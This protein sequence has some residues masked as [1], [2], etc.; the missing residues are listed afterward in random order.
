MRRLDSTVALRLALGLLA[1]GLLGQ[2]PKPSLGQADALCGR[3]RFLTLALLGR[4]CT[5]SKYAAI[6][7]I[8]RKIPGYGSTRATVGT[9]I[10]HTS[11]PLLVQD[12]PWEP[13]IDNGYPNVLRTPTGEW[14]LF[15]GTCQHS[16][17]TQILLFANSTDGL[18]WN[19]PK[20][21]LFDIGTIR[22]DLKAIGKANNVLLEGGG[23]GVT[24]DESAPPSHRYVAFGPGCYQAPNGGSCML[25]LLQGAAARARYY[26][27][28]D[29]AFSADGLTYSDARAIQWPAPQ[30]YDCHNN[31]WR[32]DT[33]GGGYEWLATTRDGFGQSP[34]RTIG[35]AR[36]MGDNLTFNTSLAPVNTFSGTTDNQLYSQ[37]TFKWAGI[38]LGIVMVY[39]ATSMAQR[40]RCKLAWSDEATRQRAWQWVDA[41]G[42]EGADFIPLGS[43]GAETFDSH[44]CFAAAV[45]ISSGGRELLYYMGGN[46]PHSGARNSSLGLATL[47][48]D[49]YAALTADGPTG[50][51]AGSVFTVPIL[52]TGPTLLATVDVLPVGGSVQIG[53]IE[54]PDVDADKALPI[55][56]NVTDAP[57]SFRGG[58][59]FSSLVG[60]MVILEL[61]LQRAS[62]YTVGFA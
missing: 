23:I 15:Y 24:R 3:M 40:V 35:I 13:R 58:G 10:K 60:K 21:G 49:G 22:P 28:Q 62:V 43:G 56:T 46:G 41:G 39:E 57:V 42:L 47:R 18:S 7:I 31:L 34:G 26:P 12:T 4:L 14:Q 30:R 9:V 55:Q 50:H 33:E 17:A 59:N 48:A 29:L 16:C 36:S 54:D 38:Y 11:N 61:R 37:V 52:C 44:I 1:L 6:G 19:K 51:D 53:C 2:A 25:N 27:T 32:D 5:C 8:D 45:P 20:L